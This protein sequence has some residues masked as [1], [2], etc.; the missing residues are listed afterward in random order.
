M[1]ITIALFASLAPLA[2]GA[3]T[4]TLASAE[5]WREDPCRYERHDAARNGTIAG[6]LLG[7]IVGVLE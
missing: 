6:G 2:L 1:R 7:A 3:A 5:A 4:P